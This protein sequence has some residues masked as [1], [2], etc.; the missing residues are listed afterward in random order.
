MKFFLKNEGPGYD[1]PYLS[2]I[3]KKYIYIYSPI[4]K[5]GLENDYGFA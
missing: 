4:L 5:S 3:N 1:L 2:K